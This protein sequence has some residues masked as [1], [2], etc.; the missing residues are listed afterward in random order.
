MC[1]KYNRCKTFV[2]VIIVLSNQYL[3]FRSIWDNIM[4]TELHFKFPIS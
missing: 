4:C 1:T 2:F 3:V